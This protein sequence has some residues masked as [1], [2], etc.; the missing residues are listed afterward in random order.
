VKALTL[1]DVRDEAE[2]DE[3]LLLFSG[4]DHL[5]D[6]ESR[7]AVVAVVHFERAREIVRKQT[8]LLRQRVR[9]LSTFREHSKAF[10][11]HLG[12]IREHLGNIQGRLRARSGK[13]QGRIRESSVATTPQVLHQNANAVQ[14]VCLLM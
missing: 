7:L 5:R 12:N 3:R 8:L 14:Q 4:A 11:G 9:A 2:G 13:V 6:F 1:N 10:R